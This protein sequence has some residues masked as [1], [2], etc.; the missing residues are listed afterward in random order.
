M[1]LVKKAKA[2]KTSRVY[3][4]DIGQDE[5]RLALAW[6]KGEVKLQQVGQAM[7][8]DKHGTKVY[9]FLASALKKH[10]NND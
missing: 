9:T 10:L 3:G 1:D 7:G 2:I 5:I 8:F 6:V 4:H